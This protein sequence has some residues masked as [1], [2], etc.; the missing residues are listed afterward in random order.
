MAL[1]D[2]VD[3]WLVEG[4]FLNADTHDSL[5]SAAYL[6]M[7]PTLNNRHFRKKMNRGE[8]NYH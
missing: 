3:G 7:F 4:Q 2:S 6:F 1:D 8:H 5:V